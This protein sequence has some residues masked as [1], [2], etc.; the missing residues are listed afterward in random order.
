MKTRSLILAVVVVASLAACRNRETALTGSYGSAVVSGQVVMSDDVA[1]SSPAGVQVLVVGTGMMTTLG[2]DGRFTFVDVPGNA[3]LLFQR[4]SD[5]ISGRVRAESTGSMIVRLGQKGAASSSRRRGATPKRE[6]EG[7]IRSVG[8]D[9]LVMFTSHKEE[10]TIA[11]DD[12]TI[13]RKGNTTLTLADLKVDDRIHVKATLK[14]GVLTALE[15]KRQNPA[16]EE[17]GDDEDGEGQTMTANG[18]VLSQ[19]GSDLVVMSQPK[20]EVTVQ[21]DGNTIIKRQGVIIAV[22]DIKAGDEVNSMGQRV[23]AS[24]LLARQIEVRG[25]SKDK[26]KGKKK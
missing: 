1:N 12:L 4:Q 16:D 9:S 26:D 10:V 25:N 18:L 11:I 15:V 2:A 14:E 23:D 6:Y 24:T 17:E 22:T 21:T 8:T 3:Q 19:S 13:I 20:G 5:G 7:V